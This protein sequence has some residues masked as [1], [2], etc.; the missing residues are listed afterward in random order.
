MTA[1]ELIVHALSIVAIL[2]AAGLLVGALL[3]VVR[4]WWRKRSLDLSD[5]VADNTADVYAEDLPRRGCCVDCVD[6][7]IELASDF[8]DI[9]RQLPD[10]DA[11]DRSLA[12][13][14]LIPE[15]GR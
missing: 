10:L 3:R 12:G 5:V 9:A 6:C 15:E 8:A 11:L 4:G 13:L 1:A 7:D 2:Y 14:Y